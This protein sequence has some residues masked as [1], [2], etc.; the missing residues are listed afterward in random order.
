MAAAGASSGRAGT[1][2]RICALRRPSLH[3][4]QLVGQLGHTGL[5]GRPSC[6]VRP[7][8]RA[9]IRSQERR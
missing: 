3:G 1:A 9:A 4:H 6:G 2:T 5:E 8:S 7:P